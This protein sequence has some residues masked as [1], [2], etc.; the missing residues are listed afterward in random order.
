MTERTV[1]H[2]TFCIERTYAAS[3]RRV[4]SRVELLE[5]VWGSSGEWQSP[6]TVTEHV[7]RLRLKLEADRDR[8]R[9][10][11]TVR[12]VGYRFEP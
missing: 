6:A 2:A 8:P 11:R 4:F 7:R 12:G 5:E 3:P 1:T 9:W 10:I